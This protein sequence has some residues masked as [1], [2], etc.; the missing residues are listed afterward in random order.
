MAF[1]AKCPVC[2]SGLHVDTEATAGVVKGGG[3]SSEFEELTRKAAA[4]EEWRA[5][6]AALE[7]AR[8]RPEENSADPPA[9]ELYT[10]L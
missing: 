8:P 3:P 2:Q 10:F 9:D 6:C 5:K 1:D 4:A 7:A